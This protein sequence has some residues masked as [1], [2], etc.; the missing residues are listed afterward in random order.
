MQKKLP[1]Q[2]EAR[3][4]IIKALAHPSRLFIVEELQ[5][6]ENSH[7]LER[8]METTNNYYGDFSSPFL[9]TRGGGTVL[10]IPLWKP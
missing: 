8:R 9:F 4:K 6:K 7:E 1:S 3:A 10:T 2:Y 5:K